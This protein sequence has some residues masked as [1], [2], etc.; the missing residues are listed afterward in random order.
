MTYA[1]TTL[2]TSHR[3]GGANG[4]YRLWIPLDEQPGY[5]YLQLF[6]W[7]LRDL[8]DWLAYP[9][10]LEICSWEVKL[11]D[12]WAMVG[13]VKAKGK[14]V[15]HV[16]GRGD[17]SWAH[18]T[19]MKEDLGHILLGADQWSYAAVAAWAA[20][21]RLT[22]AD[23]R[24]L[25]GWNTNKEWYNE[26][27]RWLIEGMPWAHQNIETW[28]NTVHWCSELP[29]IRD[30]SLWI[31]QIPNE[32]PKVQRPGYCYLMLFKEQYHEAFDWPAFPMWSEIALWDE[33][34]IV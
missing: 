11:G 25:F 15:W 29:P 7:E 28:R 32:V 18:L 5:C 14:S 34:W 27:F 12:K 6:K 16:E 19:K 4:N 8:I 22:R 3:L 20:S 23:T 30:P 2:L 21:R 9:T 1:V 26:S 33:L 17:L 31:N 24:I 10:L 13:L